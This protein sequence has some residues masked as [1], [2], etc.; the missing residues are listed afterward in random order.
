M[1]SRAR[2]RARARKGVSILG[3]AH[4]RRV[5]PDE[6]RLNGLHLPLD[7]VDGRSGGLIVDRLHPLPGQRAG[8]LDC[9][10]AHFAEAWVDGRIVAIAGFAFDHAARTEL[11]P[12]RR[13][14]RVVRVLRPL[15]RH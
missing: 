5:H 8:I 10:F 9:L 6:E 11:G 13:I 14:F 4:A 3:V 2:A 12:E 1:I 7:E 15:L